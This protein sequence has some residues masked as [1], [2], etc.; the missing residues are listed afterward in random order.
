MFYFQ[1]QTGY[2]Q[3]PK[4]TDGNKYKVSA[5]LRELNNA[6]VNA[7]MRKAL[8][9]PQKLDLLQIEDG[10]VAIDAVAEGTDGQALLR[11]LESLGLKKG[12]FYKRI[13][14][15]YFPVD[16][17]DELEQVK[18]LHKV[19]PAYKLQHGAGAV[20]TQGEAALAADKA[21]QQFK[22][23]G[24]GSKVGV[25]SDSYSSDPAGVA[26]GISSGDLPADAQILLDAVGG[27]DEGRG[28]AEIIHD[29][30]PGAKIAFH[31]ALGGQAVFANGIQKLAQAG[32]NIIVDD[33]IYYGEP[34]FQ[35]GIIAQA[36]DEV[37]KKDIAYFSAAGNNNRQSYQSPFRNSGQEV[38]ANGIN[39][40]V[41]HDFGNGDITQTIQIP[42]GGTFVIPFQWDDPFYSVSGGTGARSD[43]DVLVFFNG[44]LL[45]NLSS[46]EYNINRDPYEIVGVSNPFPTDINIEIVI[47]KFEGPDPRIIKWIDFGEGTPLEHHTKSSTI[48]GHSN[49]QGAI[50]VGA[51]AWFNTPGFNPNLTRPVINS[52]SSAGG[53][54]ILYTSAG[55][56]T[57]PNIRQKP[58]VVGPDGGNT[59][60]FGNDHSEDADTFPNFFGTSA[61]APHVAAV[62]ALMQE[63]RRNSL[64]PAA[65]AK[66]LISSA[67]D[68]NDPLTP[69]FDTGFDYQTG[70]GFVQA[71][72]ALETTL[73]YGC[74]L[75]LTTKVT[76]AQP[77]WNWPNGVGAIDLTVLGGTGPYTYR[78]NSGTATEDLPKA[79]P[80][81]YSVTVTDATGCSATTTVNVGVIDTPL[82]VT[83]SHTNVSRYGAADGSIDLSVIGGTGPYTFKWNAGAANED[84][85]RV[86]HGLYTVWVI[87][88]TGDSAYT[89]VYVSAYKEP[90]ALQ[91]AHNPASRSGAD[92]GSIDLTVIGGVAPY[93]YRWNAGVATEDLPR[94]TPGLYTVTVTDATGATVTTSVYVSVKGQPLALR[95]SHTDASDWGK[96]DGSI[97]LTIVG[98]VAPYKVKWN[99]GSAMEDLPRVLPGIYKVTVTDA[100]GATATLTVE[101]G[102]RGTKSL[103][104]ARK[105]DT[106][107]ALNT[108]P[109]K[110]TSLTAYPNP[111]NNKATIA[112]TLSQSGDYA[113]EVYDLKGSLIKTLK[114]GKAQAGK[115]V[116]AEWEPQTTAKGIYL[117]RLKTQ[118]EVQNLRLMVN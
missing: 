21:R 20:T 16:K 60:F 25:I 12:V 61:A 37:V 52:F 48:Y 111:V 43:L 23:S 115:T 11:Q 90:L 39:F 49:A 29:V 114:Q 65:I 30:A 47:T 45:I 44:S 98:G 22:V 80:G 100:K 26:A 96:D 5:D 7:R 63:S 41:A 10:Y 36:V 53:T 113:L 58:E 40:G 13:V 9:G 28:M 86:T 97:D 118:H 24:V 8:T 35:D 106:A 75:S 78:W 117:L 95:A 66:N 94:A 50:T 3:S 83:S 55:Q 74:N 31:T 19:S 112:V 108:N 73:T 54:P 102:V 64:S 99:A 59:T 70:Y 87:D 38:V 101:V 68:M 57:A 82:T 56:R 2:T 18:A 107:L 81:L 116:E 92:D 104:A 1:I 77:G 42:A 69:G 85:S 91:T 103:L 71:T 15:G 51:T 34:M 105:P 46:T 88:A 27:T 89:A 109:D 76:Q 84:L 6:P 67:I 79:T 110:K 72:K 93:T 14:S 33:V 32:C 62:A 17:I 4:Y